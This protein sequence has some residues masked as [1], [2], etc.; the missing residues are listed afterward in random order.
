M[1][2][3]EH[4]CVLTYNFY[5][6]AKVGFVLFLYYLKKYHQFFEATLSVSMAETYLEQ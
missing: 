6:R 2:I 3:Y 5:P 4:F 1:F